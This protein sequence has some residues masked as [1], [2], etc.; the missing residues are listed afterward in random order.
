MRHGDTV[1]VSYTPPAS[2]P[3]RDLAGNTAD[4]L[5]DKAVENQIPAPATISSVALSSDPGTDDTYAI[6]DTIEAT[7]TFDRPVKVDSAADA[8]SLELDV[9]GT[10]RQAA[11][12]SGSGDAELEFS[13]TVVAGDED[14][15][16]VSIGENK[17][18]DD[19]EAI[20]HSV[21][22]EGSKFCACRRRP[23]R[24][25]RR[26]RPQGGRGGADGRG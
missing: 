11:Y 25:R 20:G 22:V 14:A 4:G 1:T 16:G 23:R 10:A 12:S 7:V 18:E 2:N 26:R 19:D 5:T 3:V 9:G 13:Y 21:E 24:R 6:G 17:L 15:D 8:P